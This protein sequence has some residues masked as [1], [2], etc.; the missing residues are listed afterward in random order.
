VDECLGVGGSLRL[1][2]ETLRRGGCAVQFQGL[3]MR[4]ALKLAGRFGPSFT[5]A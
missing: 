5:S 4:L 1:H 3:A 2:G